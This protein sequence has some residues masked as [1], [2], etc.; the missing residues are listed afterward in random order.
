MNVKVLEGK[1]QYFILHGA[2]KLTLKR[3]NDEKHMA[4]SGCGHI[5]TGQNVTEQF[6]TDQDLMS[7]SQNVT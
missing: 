3:A 7:Q 1:T 6:F 2:S 5:V 4:F